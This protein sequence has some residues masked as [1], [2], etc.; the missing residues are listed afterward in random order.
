[1]SVKLGRTSPSQNVSSVQRGYGARCD[2]LAL[3]EGRRTAGTEDAA[4]VS[5][6]S[7]I[8]D[9]MVSH[10]AGYMK[11]SIPHDPRTLEA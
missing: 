2:R 11:V 10:M 9:A 8:A 7:A 6:T 3:R 5:D 4:A 1:M